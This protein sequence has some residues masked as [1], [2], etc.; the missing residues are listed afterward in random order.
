MLPEP[1]FDVFV[2]LQ[3]EAKSWLAPEVVASEPYRL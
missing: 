3:E 2:L 1:S